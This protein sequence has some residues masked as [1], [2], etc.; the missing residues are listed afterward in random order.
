L[1]H[2]R[3]RAPVRELGGAAWITLEGLRQRHRIALRL[4]GSGLEGIGIEPAFAIGQRALLVRAESGNILWDCIPLIDEAIV[5]AVRALGGIAAIAICHPHYYAAM[6]E[7]CHAFDRAPIYLH[8][9]DR[10]W[11]MR[12][13]PAIRFWEG[14]RHQLGPGLT[15]IQ[16]GGHFPGGTVLHWT[17]RAGGWGALLT[18][19][20]LQVAD[21]R[22][23][24]SFMYSYPNYIPLDAAAVR[25]I[26]AAVD[27]FAYDELYG[28]WWDRRIASDARVAVRR[29]GERYLKAI[30]A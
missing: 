12:P 6:V 17:G 19:D 21:D 11:V 16:C 9:A 22:R 5:E 24:V 20:V 23:H 18:G 25:R 28:A 14:E 29:S 30:V 4:E 8:A 1:C 3:G 10:P 7:W 15:L 2:L 27:P 26:L 13:D